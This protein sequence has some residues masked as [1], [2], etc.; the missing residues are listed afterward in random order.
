MQIPSFGGNWVDLVILGA[1]LFFMI[2]GW[3]FGLLII[4]AGFVSFF[5]SL[6][7]SLRLYQFA[8]EII[9]DNFA[10][11][12]ALSNALGFLATAVVI[13]LILGKIISFLVNKIPKR[14]K[15]SKLNKLLGVI[16]ALGEGIVLVAFVLVV[17]VAS[18]I[19]PGLKEDISD[20]RIGGL[21]LG[22]T[23][24][25]EAAIN[26][27]FGSAVRDSLTYLTVKPDS[28]EAIALEIQVGE[29]S[30]DTTAEQE[31]FDLINKERRERGVNELQWREQLIPIARAHATDMWE[32]KYFS[33]FSPEGKDIGDR[34]DEKVVLYVFA[35]ENLALA[36]TIQT[37]HDGLMN[38]EGHRENI[39]DSKFRK[40]A[41]GVIDNGVYGKMFVQLFSD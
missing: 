14:I 25:V 31:M 9:R 4:G 37:A 10:L 27:A 35:G 8:A 30:I 39:L 19:N 26:N 33:H 6:L 20:S 1:F 21:I 24:A 18:P 32:R 38:S 22:K 40:A 23:T 11:S 7:V 2:E 41:V 3:R 15:R 34:L 29:L 5:I 13:E 28:S 16:P 12:R 17:I 36:P